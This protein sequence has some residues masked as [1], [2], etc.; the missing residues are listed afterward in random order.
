MSLTTL[1]EDMGLIPWLAQWVGDLELPWTVV[2]VTD[3]A[4]IWCC[5]GQPWK[6]PHAAGAALKKKKKNLNHYVVYI[7]NSYNIVQQLYFNKWKKN[8]SI[9][10]SP[11]QVISCFYLAIAVITSSRYHV[12][13]A[14]HKCINSLKDAI[15]GALTEGRLRLVLV[16]TAGPRTNRLQPEPA[17]RQRRRNGNGCS[18]CHESVS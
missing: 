1:H 7:Y 12:W 17:H 13:W 8:L 16:L 2:Y 4:Q 6:L 9:S 11:H 5:C 10:D 15:E 18:Q 14:L 3:V